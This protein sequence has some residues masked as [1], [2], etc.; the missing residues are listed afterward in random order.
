L[1]G[2][3]PSADAQSAETVDFSFTGSGSIAYS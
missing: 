3:D 1:A 2:I